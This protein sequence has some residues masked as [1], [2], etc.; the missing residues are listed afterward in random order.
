MRPTS[1]I[2]RLG[3]FLLTGGILAGATA[4]TGEKMPLEYRLVADWPTLPP[5]LKLGGISAVAT[6]ARDNVYLLNRTKPHVVV[7]DSSGKLLRSWNGDFKTPHGLRIDAEGNLWIADMANHLVQKFTPD[8][9]LLLKLGQKNEAGLAEDKFNKPADANVGPNGEIYV[10]DGYGNS[11]IAKFTKDGKFIQDWG[12]KGK[13]HGE[14]N[15]PHVVMLDGEQRV[16]VGDREN[17]RVQ[18]FDQAGKFLDLW[19]DTGAPYGLYIYK[20]RVYLA[21]G[22]KGTIRV[23]DKNGK[24]LARWDPGVGKGEVPHWITVDTKGAVYIG[25]VSGKKVQKWVA[26]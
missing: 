20:D 15:L 18:L 23:L 16:V 9:K 4:L 3:L 24:P 8:G 7:F 17:L 2:L 11:R 13:G 21:D 25:W 26:K 14:F 6:D 1:P 22:R 10:A 5:D 19:K 12:K